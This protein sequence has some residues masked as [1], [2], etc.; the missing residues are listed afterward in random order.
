MRLALVVMLVLGAEGLL[1]PAILAAQEGAAVGGHVHRMHAR[2][3]DGAVLVAEELRWPMGVPP[4][5]EWELAL[6]LP[7][8][9]V[10]LGVEACGPQRCRRGSPMEAA[11][12][13][14]DAARYAAHAPGDA[15]L[16]LAEQHGAWVR[17]GLAGLEPDATVRLA[18][19]V[20]TE[21][22]GGRERVLVPAR[23]ERLEVT[24]TSPELDDLAIDGDPTARVVEP[25]DR[26][27]EL[28][29][30]RT[31]S[32][33]TMRAATSGTRGWARL[34]VPPRAA[35]ARDVIVFLDASPSAQAH[36]HHLV[37]TLA[38]LLEV[39]PDGSHVRVIALART[40]RTIAAGP[41]E[42]VRGTIAA[43]PTDLGPS[44]SAHAALG[45]AGMALGPEPVLVWLGDGGLELGQREDEA[46]ADLRARGLATV[47]LSEGRVDAR[48]G[49]PVVVDPDRDPRA[50]APRLA[51]LLLPIERRTVAGIT[52]VARPGQSAWAPLV[53]A[54]RVAT[55][56]GVLPPAAI[57]PLVDRALGGA[58]PTP[59]FL[60][61]AAQD[62]DAA[63]KTARGRLALF[64]VG[65]GVLPRPRVIACWGCGGDLSAPS[66]QALRRVMRQSVL[67]RV[68]G[69]FAD[70][71]RG[72][73]DW[74]G[75]V[76]LELVLEGPELVHAQIEAES[77]AMRA[78]VDRALDHLVLPSAASGR[79]IVRYPF[80][81][82][83]VPRAEPAPGAMGATTAGLLDALF[84]SEPSVPPPALLAPP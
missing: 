65:G 19:S 62:R 24:L 50:M 10:L 78:C 15:P 43:L 54:R 58:A 49:T 44:T 33:T 79:V 76:V 28:S 36:A 18:W 11:A 20:R 38:T 84:A 41:I 2:F 69:C 1:A 80:V 47:T 4:R 67:P 72:R 46:I 83:A 12:D 66:V 71:R 40:A 55:T 22:I 64:R 3:G 7:D 14:Y 60:T 48:L 68:R 56:R 74:T 23:E 53:G 45:E 31:A 26:A 51:A 8:G 5:E 73:P 57:V 13:V 70:A 21:G 35:A 39:V 81:S 34:E 77:E 63:R 52:L 25:N 32:V 29:G 30:R 6:R 59:A 61:L 27:F 82:E 16:V 17:L 75:R 42:T 9:A 37:R